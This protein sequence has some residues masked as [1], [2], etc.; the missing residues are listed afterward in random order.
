MIDIGVVYGRFQILH[1]KHLEYILAAK[2][3]C[4]KLYIGIVFPDDSCLSEG[5]GLDYRNKKSANPL[6]YLERY[7][8]IRDALLDFKVPR[9]DF[10]IVP[11]PLERPQYLWEYVPKDASYFLSICDEWTKKNRQMFESRGLKTEVLWT[12]EP[13]DKG[14]TGTQIRQRII[15]GEKWSDL[16]PRNVFDYVKEHGIDNRIRFTK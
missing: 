7:D 14:T 4:R 2:M 10:E 13:E 9:E 6:T 11:F 12:R 16:V 3:R 5:D 8:M 15:A 1:L